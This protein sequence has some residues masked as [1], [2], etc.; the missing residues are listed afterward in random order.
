[1][2]VFISTQSWKNKIGLSVSRRLERIADFFREKKG[3]HL[4]VQCPSCKV[5]SEIGELLW[6]GQ[7][8]ELQCPSCKSFFTVYIPA[9][10]VKQGKLEANFRNVTTN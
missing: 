3:V 6:F 5:D 7:A 9:V 2:R 4:E 10:Q 1:M 8:Y